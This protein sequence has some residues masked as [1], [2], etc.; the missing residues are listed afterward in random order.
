M[1]RGCLDTS[2][3]HHAQSHTLVAIHEV[4]E[5]FTS[6][7]YGNTFPIT[8]FVQSAVNAQ[9]SFPVLTVGCKQASRKV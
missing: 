4:A 5:V 6:S 9:V 1:K 3:T 8:E 7:R 2:K